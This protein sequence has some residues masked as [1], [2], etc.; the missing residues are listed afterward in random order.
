[1]RQQRVDADILYFAREMRR[2]PTRA[3]AVLWER[4]SGRRLNCWKCR[5]FN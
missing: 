5:A 2:E 3:E 1:M 4:L